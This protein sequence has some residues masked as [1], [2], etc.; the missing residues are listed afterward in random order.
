MII[1]VIAAFAKTLPGVHI[2]FL[3][4][5]AMIIFPRGKADPENVSSVMSAVCEWYSTSF[6]TGRSS[7][8]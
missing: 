3:T 1:D 2:S 8:A 4:T 7:R 5:S 6:P